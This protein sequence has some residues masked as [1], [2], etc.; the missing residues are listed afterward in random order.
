MSG[1][2]SG[3]LHTLLKRVGGPFLRGK[4]SVS[5]DVWRLARHAADTLCE[6]VKH[7]ILERFGTPLDSGEPSGYT[8]ILR[9]PLSI[10]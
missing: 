7:G 3:E 6:R 5:L 8:A 4:G 1:G 9:C 2:W 10:P